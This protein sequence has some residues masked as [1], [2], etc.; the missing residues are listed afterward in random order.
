M[1]NIRM[2][3][4][5]LREIPT[6]AAL[7]INAL[8]LLIPQGE[9]ETL[10]SVLDLETGGNSGGQISQ[11]VLNNT[12]CPVFRF[13]EN[14]LLAETPSYTQ[15]I[16]AILRSRTLAFGITCDGITTVDSSRLQFSE[17]PCCMRIASSP[18]LAIASLDE[19]IVCISTSE[20]LAA[21]LPRSSSGDQAMFL[22]DST[23]V[24]DV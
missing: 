11:I 21:C 7:Q 22:S 6:F 5:E 24:Q 12:T 13:D 8:M 1:A 16:C 18:V 3:I 9:I 23:E 15:R 14:L 2:T 20:D 4:E 17:L 19:E 10:E